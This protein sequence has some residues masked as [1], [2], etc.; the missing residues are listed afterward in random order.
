VNSGLLYGE[1]TA[2]HTEKAREWR[3]HDVTRMQE[4]CAL[5][6]LLR[7]CWALQGKTGVIMTVTLGTQIDKLREL[8]LIFP[9]I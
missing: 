7:C 2:A 3:Q 9:L 6:F 8:K 4:S 5:S 1:M